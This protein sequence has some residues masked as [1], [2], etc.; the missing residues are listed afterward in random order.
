MKKYLLLSLMFLA[1]CLPED[2]VAVR[3]VSLSADAIAL[4]VGQ[5]RSLTAS[6]LPTDADNLRIDWSTTDETVAT[7]DDGGFIRAIAVGEATVTVT[8]RDGGKSS[9]CLVTVTA[10]QSPLLPIERSYFSM[11]EGEWHSAPIPKTTNGAAPQSVSVSD[12]EA[13]TTVTFQSDVE[14]SGIFVGVKG[15][16]G[17]FEADATPVR[18]LNTR[19]T[20]TYGFQ[21]VLSDNLAG[22]FTMILTVHAANGNIIFTTEVKVGPTNDPKLV[23]ADKVTVSPTELALKAG[24]TASLTASVAPANVFDKSVGWAS[25][26][27]NVAT[28]SAS[29]VVTAIGAGSATIT[30]TS[31]DGKQS[32][33]CAVT[34]EGS[35]NDV[36]AV[37][38][39]ALFPTRLDMEVGG[40]RTLE[41]SIVPANATN[42]NV[43]FLSMYDNVATVSPTGEVEAKAIG[44]TVITITTEDGSWIDAC[45]VTVKA[46]VL[47][48]LKY[49]PD[50]NFLNYVRGEMPTWDKNSDAILSQ[51]EAA[52]VKT[53]N[54]NG[55]N[56]ASMMGL[57]FF[58]GLTSLSCSQNNLTRLEVSNLTRLTQ[59]VCNNN[60]LPTLILSAN[61]ALQTLDVSNN[62]LA[63]ID[64]SA[65]TSLTS[66]NVGDNELT[67]IDISKNT[68]LLFFLCAGN[69]GNGTV[70]P[71]DAW[72]DSAHVPARFTKGV[73][74]YNGVT[75]APAYPTPVVI[76]V[77]GVELTPSAVGLKV[78]A[79]MSLVWEVLPANATNKNVGW[80]SSDE[81]VATVSATGVVTALAAGQTVVTITTEDGSKTGVCTVTVAPV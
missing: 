23:T 4:Q 10:A 31:A 46:Y 77:T 5:T 33:G 78:G 53:I 30:A 42:K 73:W 17:Y 56:I 54:A 58:T 67:G 52:A 69:P 48:V 36:V 13:G 74:D 34:V 1:G 57:E 49:I 50:A 64:L 7:V 70:L 45:S 15:L 79:Q 27:E 38:G 41:W 39:V 76:A 71:I 18:A 81:N 28:V 40:E 66:L 62:A 14:L 43:R 2:K 55:R 59:L 9:S 35:P 63:Q 26:D 65:L 29:G 16:T 61:T 19:A 8:S 51:E 72:F 25:S 37:A 11:A 3:S 47:D 20:Q 32:S 12:G 6:V 22:D 60:S 68:A 44:T 24:E 21:I 75:I 80:T